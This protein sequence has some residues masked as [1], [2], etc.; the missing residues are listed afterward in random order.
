MYPKRPGRSQ[1][2]NLCYIYG[3][4]NIDGLI[5]SLFHHD[6]II[7]L[8]HRLARFGFSVRNLVR[9]CPNRRRVV[10]LGGILEFVLKAHGLSKGGRVEAN[11]F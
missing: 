6:P 7:N 11:C 3:H 8:G 2:E 4:I 10:L 1:N 5:L 9:G